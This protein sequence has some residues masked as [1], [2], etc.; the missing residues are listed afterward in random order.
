MPIRRRLAVAAAVAVAIAIATASLAAYLAVRSQLRGEVDSA[1]HERAE[2]IQMIV[3]T[4]GPMQAPPSRQDLPEPPQ[5]RF[6]GAAGFVQFLNSD[7]RVKVQAALGPERLPVT[8]QARAV[9]TGSESGDVFEDET[10]DGDHLRVLTTPL[11]GGGAVQ[12]ARPLD[13]VDSVMEQLILILVIV[14]VGGIGLAALLGTL[15]S[16]AS[17]AP[18]RRFTDE[19]ESILEGPD[20]SRRLPDAGEDELGRLA[21]SYNATL[22]ALQGSADAQRQMVSDASHELRTPLASLKANLELLLRGERRLGEG[23]RE[24]LE[25]ELVEQIDELTLLVDDVVELARRGEPEPMLLDGIELSEIVA[26]EVERARRHAPGLTFDVQ[27][28][29]CAIRGVPERLARAVHNLVDNAAKWSPDGS[30]VEVSLDGGV[31]AVRDHGP[32]FAP[33]DLPFVF[34]RF[35]RARAAR[36]QR[37]SGLGLAIVRQTAEAHGAEAKAANAPGGGAVLTLSFPLED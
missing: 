5:A 13:E 22:D 31:L 29:P 1:L 3:E 23:D 36:S 8:R 37:G 34:D 12:V 2:G 4:E 21:R 20:L 25:R 26:G 30:T 17:L 32:G 27:L 10:V 11:E 9:A 6:G 16:R 35:Y 7:G 33:E 24:E 28:E 14:T 15:V 18:V 19:T